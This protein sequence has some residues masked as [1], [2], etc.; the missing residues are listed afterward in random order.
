MESEVLERPEPEEDVRRG[1][2]D[3]NLYPSQLKRLILYLLVSI[4]FSFF[5]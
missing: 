5:Y 3:A 2:K 1:R 4:V